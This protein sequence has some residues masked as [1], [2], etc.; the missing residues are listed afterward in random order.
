[1][2]DVNDATFDMPPKEAATHVGGA[3]VLASIVASKSNDHCAIVKYT[4]IVVGWF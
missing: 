3:P 4:K 2:Q 1:M